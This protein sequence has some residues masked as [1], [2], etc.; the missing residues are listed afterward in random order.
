MVD[1]VGVFI[2]TQRF[3][4]YPDPSNACLE[5]TIYR[6]RRFSAFTRTFRSISKGLAVIKRFLTVVAAGG[7]LGG[8]LAVGAGAASAAPDA[9]KPHTVCGVCW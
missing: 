2:Q 4:H 9:D 1:R 6:L 3:Q 5:P 7:I 8:L